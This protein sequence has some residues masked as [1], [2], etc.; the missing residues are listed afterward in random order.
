MA[1]RV[2]TRGTPTGIDGRKEQREAEG[3]RLGGVGVIIGQASAR[4]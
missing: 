4:K 3:T 2:P 1:C